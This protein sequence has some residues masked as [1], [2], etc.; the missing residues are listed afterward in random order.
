M[1]WKKREEGEEAEGE[2][3]EKEEGEE[4]EGEM[5]EKEEEDEEQEGFTSWNGGADTGINRFAQGLLT[6]GD[7]HER[8]F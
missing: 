7:N 1:K 3:E 8:T 4:A 2:M 5:E 6:G